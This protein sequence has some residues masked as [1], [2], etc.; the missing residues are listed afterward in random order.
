MLIKQE[1]QWILLD[2]ILTS[3]AHEAAVAPNASFVMTRPRSVET[4]NHLTKVSPEVQLFIITELQSH[5]LQ[6]GIA[7][8]ANPQPYSDLNSD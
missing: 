7:S 3:P 2:A 5:G 1:V 8:F 4:R 6:N